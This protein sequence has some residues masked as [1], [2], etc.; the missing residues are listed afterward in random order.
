MRLSL[1]P[2][3]HRRHRLL[4]L[5]AA[6]VGVAVLGFMF[7]FGLLAIAL[8][9]VVGVVMLGVR[10]WRLHQASR[11]GQSDQSHGANPPPPPPGVIEGEFVVMQSR[12][13]ARSR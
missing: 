10:Q 3:H 12:H 2:L 8:L 1:P 9:L 5:L 13:H 6:V 7:V 11:K 4:R